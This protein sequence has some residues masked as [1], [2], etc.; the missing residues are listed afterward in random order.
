MWHHG[1]A[2]G[3]E[4]S[5]VRVCQLSFLLSCFFGLPRTGV[6]H[7]AERGARLP[8]EFS[9]ELFLRFATD[10][11]QTPSGSRSAF[12]NRVSVEFFLRNIKKI[13]CLQDSTCQVHEKYQISENPVK[14]L[15]FQPRPSTSFYLYTALDTGIPIL[16]VMPIPPGAEPNASNIEPLQPAHNDKPV[17]MTWTASEGVQNNPVEFFAIESGTLQ[18]VQLVLRYESIQAQLVSAHQ[19]NGWPSVKI[20]KPDREVRTPSCSFCLNDSLVSNGFFIQKGEYFE[21]NSSAFFGKK[22]KAE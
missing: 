17:F 4:R 12:A 19:K 14:R 16:S 21:L 13:H 6:R 20:R 15:P 7:R 2:S 5:A 18:A 8:I 9:V 3:T 22:S 10:R 1:P 11:R